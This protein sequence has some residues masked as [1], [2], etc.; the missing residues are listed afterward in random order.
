[1]VVMVREVADVTA[2]VGLLNPVLVK[3]AP[4]AISVKSVNIDVTTA[5]MGVTVTMAGMGREEA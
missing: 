2:K 4:T 3:K 5:A 1:M